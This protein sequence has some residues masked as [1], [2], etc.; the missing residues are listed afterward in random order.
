MAILKTIK[1]FQVFNYPVN[2]DE[3]YLYLQKKTSKMSL[4]RNL[5][6]LIKNKHVVYDDKHNKYTLGE[7]SINKNPRIKIQRSKLLSRQAISQRKIQKIQNYIR[8]LSLFPQILLIGLSGSLAMM[9]ADKKD[10]IDLFIITSTNRLWTGRLV[11]LLLAQL[12]G[13]RRERNSQSAQ[14]KAC[15]NLFFDAKQ[16]T[17][18]KKKQTIYV[19]HEILQMK[20]LINKQSIYEY[21]LK[22]NSWVYRLFPNYPKIRINKH[23]SQKK[24]LFIGDW[25]EVITKKLQLLL[26]NRHKTK[27][28]ITED[29]LWFFPEDFEK[30]I[31]DI[32]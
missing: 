5:A 10:D 27:E 20:P 28:I 8:I 31:I 24:Q 15:L 13:I 29:Q 11:S 4:Q 32:I 3:V 6:L 12:F 16:L 9:N 1:Y 19:A 26:I 21:F 18:P 2:F 14:D 23:I 30:K 25:I 22:M 17:I 7:Y